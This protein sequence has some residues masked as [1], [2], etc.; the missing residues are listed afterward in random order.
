[1]ENEKDILDIQEPQIDKFVEKEVDL[2]F[3]DHF[4]FVENNGELT[5]QTCTRIHYCSCD[6]DRCHCLLDLR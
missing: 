5:C 3:H 1:M 6:C 2:G 4:V